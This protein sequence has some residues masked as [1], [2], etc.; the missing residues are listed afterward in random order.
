VEDVN[1]RLEFHRALDAVA[2]PAPW[3]SA[4]VREGLRQR[5]REGWID[6]ARRRPPIRIQWM[7]PVVAALLAVAI[8]ATLVLGATALRWIPT[9]PVHPFPHLPLVIKSKIPPCGG[10]GSAGP[11]EMFGSGA[12]WAGGSGYLADVA[13]RAV[14][15]GPYR[16]SDGGVHWIK[17][18]P[19]AIATLSPDGETDFFL[20]STHAWVAE[21]AG[22]TNATADHVVVF[23]TRDAGQTWQQ[24]APL[25]I[26]PADSSD[27]IWSGSGG[28]HWMCFIDARN[29]V[30]LIESGPASPMAPLWR[31]GALYRTS[32]GGLNWNLVSTNP[33]STALKTLGGSCARGFG[34]GDGMV[35]SS[36]ITGWLPLIGCASSDA[37]LITHDGGITWSAQHMRVTYPTLPYFSDSDH[38][39]MAGSDSLVATSDGGISWVSRGVLPNQANSVTFI[40]SHGWCIVNAAPAPRTDWYLYRTA[41]GGGTWSR[42]SALPTIGGLTFL[43]MNT[44]FLTAGQY[45][46]SLDWLLFR[47]VDG[48]KSWTR[49]TSTIA[50]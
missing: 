24:S 38:G 43:D 36:S 49:V 46:G 34:I 33:G 23:S 12:G 16:T 4:H 42:E 50:P 21:A 3:L 41:D 22:S 32:D 11:V 39:V 37:V 6:R 44:G 31:T 1:L 48:G 27:V 25:R 35:F 10:P 20:D 26:V 40:D 9:I 15:N 14:A 13:G 19:P 45:P 7:L 2:P 28:A 8:V 17:V 18:A 47:T 5:Q 30:L 29:G